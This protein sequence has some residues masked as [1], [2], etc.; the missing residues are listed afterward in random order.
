MRKTKFVA[1]IIQAVVIGQWKKEQMR[2]A[3]SSVVKPQRSHS[4][5][6]IRP[7]ISLKSGARNFEKK[8]SDGHRNGRGRAQ[9]K[10]A[11]DS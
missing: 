2:S 10:V 3:T 6:P 4:A 5:G 1:L 7:R 8:K 11:W 9:A